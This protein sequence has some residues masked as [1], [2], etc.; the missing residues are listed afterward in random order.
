[1]KYLNEIPFETPN[2]KE[3]FEKILQKI[4]NSSGGLILSFNPETFYLAQTKP[5][6]KKLFQ[7]ALINL[8][9]GVGIVWAVK[10]LTGQTIPRLPGV[11]LVEALFRNDSGPY[12]FWGSKPEVIKKLREVTQ[13]Q[14]QIQ[15]AGVQ[16]GYYPL[17]QESSILSRIQSLTPKFIL[18]GMG[19]PRQ[20]EIAF[21]LNQLCPNAF[22]IPCGGS[23][24]VL[25]S[26][27][28]RAPLIFRTLN[29]EWL[30]RLST[31]P[32]R[33]KRSLPKLIWFFLLIIFKKITIRS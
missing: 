7:S 16:D 15:I 33:I 11:E 14:Y 29:L 26:M 27:T 24:D 6:F 25:S 31:Q 28:P 17:E 32:F 3:G 4:Q 12:F 22:I 2:S 30:Y 5:F 10:F 8:P 18:I 13:A 21:K 1:M 20:E 19:S 9:D 23:F